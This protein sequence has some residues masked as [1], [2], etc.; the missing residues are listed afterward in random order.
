METKLWALLIP[1]PDDVW[2]MTSLAAAEEAKVKHNEL[3]DRADW[4]LP[5]LRAQCQ[6][7]V[8]EWPHS[9]EMHAEALANDEPET[10]GDDEA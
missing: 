9:A 8:I 4:P 2:A 7:S 5:E 3:V 10:L 1:G 6:A